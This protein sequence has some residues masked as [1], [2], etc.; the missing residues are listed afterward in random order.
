[1][2]KRTTERSG[3]GMLDLLF[4]LLTFLLIA[5][6]ALYVRACEKL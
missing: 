1:M 3:D 4:V 5:L 6:S 2:R